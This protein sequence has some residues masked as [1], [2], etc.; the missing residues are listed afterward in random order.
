[1]ALARRHEFRDRPETSLIIEA[2]WHYRA[3]VFVHELHN[4]AAVHPPGVRCFWSKVRKCKPTKLFGIAPN[5]FTKLGSNLAVSFLGRS[6]TR[7]FRR[8][9][10]LLIAFGGGAREPYF[11]GNSQQAD[12]PGAFAIKAI[13]SGVSLTHRLCPSA[14]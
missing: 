5:R 4:V 13:S 11:W 14:I 9:A 3:A 6:T 1:M 7:R 2:G 12:H 10:V 8:R